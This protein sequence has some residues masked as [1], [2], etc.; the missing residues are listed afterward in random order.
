MPIERSRFLFPSVGKTEVAVFKCWF[1]Q[2]N[3]VERSLALLQ[4]N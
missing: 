2:S 3:D 1:A 4:S